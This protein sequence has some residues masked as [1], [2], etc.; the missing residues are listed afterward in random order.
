MNSRFSGNLE[1]LSAKRKGER[2]RDEEQRGGKDGEYRDGERER[3]EGKGERE[4]ERG[5]SLRANFLHRI[6]VGIIIFSYSYS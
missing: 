3:G 2:E 4:R 5:S 6:I 1:K